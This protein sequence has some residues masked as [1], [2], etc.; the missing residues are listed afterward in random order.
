MPSRRIPNHLVQILQRRASAGSPDPAYLF[1]ANGE[2]ESERLSFADLDRRA[3]AIGAQL[4][5]LKLSGE[6]VL[7]LH[8]PGLGFVEAFFGC[9][10]AGA[11]AVPAYPPRAR[12]VDPRLRAIAG[13]C[14]PRAAL[15]DRQLRPQE[16]AGGSVD[17]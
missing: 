2:V 4:Q 8:P 9:L 1:L 3:R 7:L 6:R 10:Y 11:V 12:G 14:A 16:R 5:A 17:S 13:D 15:A